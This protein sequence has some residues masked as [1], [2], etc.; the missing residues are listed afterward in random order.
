MFKNSS[1]S[2]REYQDTWKILT[3]I[4]LSKT[5]RGYLGVYICHGRNEQNILETL[6]IIING[7]I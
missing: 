3:G 5:V 4:K 7:K 6:A 2:Q 1:V